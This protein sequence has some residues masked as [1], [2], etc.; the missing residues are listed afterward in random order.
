MKSQNLGG[1]DPVKL[2]EV[3]QKAQAPTY[4]PLQQVN[5]RAEAGHWRVWL[6]SVGA[7]ASMVR[8]AMEVAFSAL[9]ALCRG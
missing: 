6:S 2:N 1:L 5:L 4:Q 7:S 3:F 9:N 8:W